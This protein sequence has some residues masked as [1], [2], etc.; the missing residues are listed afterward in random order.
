MGGCVGV[1]IEG[2][3]QNIAPLQVGGIVAIDAIDAIEAIDAIVGVVDFLGLWGAVWRSGG[4]DLGV[5]VRGEDG[6]Y[7]LFEGGYFCFYGFVFV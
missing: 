3:A 5:E 1:G 2:R 6:C 7:C 4:E